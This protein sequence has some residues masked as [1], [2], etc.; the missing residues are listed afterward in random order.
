MQSAP[1]L[2]G[3]PGSP[4]VPKEKKRTKEV[5]RAKLTE[6]THVAVAYQEIGETH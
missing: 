5:Q 2:P 3:D 6:E 4:S 1:Q